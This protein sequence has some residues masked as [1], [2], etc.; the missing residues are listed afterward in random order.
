MQRA[1]LVLLS[2]APSVYPSALEEAVA[3]ASALT[4]DNMDKD[5]DRRLTRREVESGFLLHQ[6]TSSPHLENEG[7]SAVRTTARS[8][9]VFVRHAS[10]TKDAL[11]AVDD[12]FADLDMNGDDVITFDEFS[13]VSRGGAGGVRKAEAA[14][15]QQ[16][17][18]ISSHAAAMCSRF[19]CVAPMDI[20]KTNSPLSLVWL[21]Y[22]A[23][24]VLS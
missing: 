22:S 1:C 7:D 15:A 20:L 12:V 13:A 19:V 9:G 23:P 3:A 5:L 6:L 17:P 24:E 21:R 10:A 8:D 14:G 2:S 11:S 18:Q 16:A 4:F